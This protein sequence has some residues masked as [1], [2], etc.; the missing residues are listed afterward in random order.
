[1]VCDLSEPSSPIELM[2]GV[3]VLLAGPPCQ[4]FSTAGKR[5]F[6]DPRNSLLAIA[7]QIATRV[8][9][10]VFLAEN[11]SGVTAG[12]HKQHWYRLHGT[13]RAAGYRTTDI[14]C[15][16][17]KMG[18]PQIRRRMVMLAWI[19]KR[20]I[21]VSLPVH[22]GGTV[23]SALVGVQGKPNHDVKPLPPH[24][25]L[26]R[27]ARRIKPGQKLSNVRAG[28]RSVHTWEIP[29]VFGETTASERLLLEGL[30]R[31]PRR[32]RTRD[33]GDADPVSASALAR[34]LGQPV[35]ETLVSLQRKG[36]VRRVNSH[37]DLTHSFNGKFRR[38]RWDEPS[39]TVDTRFGSPRYFLHPEANRGFTVREAAR[40]QG[41]SDSFHFSGPESAQYRMIG[42]AVPPPVS[43]IL[44]SFVSEAL[45]CY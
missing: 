18:A 16:T 19:A 35:A 33:F 3:G 29:E 31:L 21:R 9:P 22:E 32:R 12:E 26:W 1:M 40:I 42:N 10:R 38:L 8:R 44:A 2:R 20:D 39:L 45:M 34:C 15:L 13:L 27:I 7:A 6:D 37:F 30:L 36:F 4:G 17:A 14:V 23:R 24:S 25:D 11:V 5:D 43:R 28:P 41:F